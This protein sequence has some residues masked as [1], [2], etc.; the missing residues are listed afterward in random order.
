MNRVDDIIVFHKLQKTHIEQITALLLRRLA[1]RLQAMG[2]EITFTDALIS[3]LAEAG[4]DKM[5]GARPIRRCIQTEVED[6][7]SEQLLEGKIAKGQQIVGDYTD[8]GVVF[9]QA[10]EN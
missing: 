1:V 4:F 5:Y 8:A 9:A 3:H 6:A 10:S 7:L 2:I